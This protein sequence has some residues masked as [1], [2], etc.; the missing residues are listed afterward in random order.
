MYLESRKWRERESN[1]ASELLKVLQCQRRQISVWVSRGWQG[2][3]CLSHHLPHLREWISENAG[4]GS[5][6]EGAET[7]EFCCWI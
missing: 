3:R 7:L 2:H 6:G 4:I 1:C 5:G